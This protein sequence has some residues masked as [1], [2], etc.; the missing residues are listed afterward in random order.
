V[1]VASTDPIDSLMTAKEVA[2]R[3]GLNR[4]TIW[5]W[6]NSGLV[7]KPVVQRPK[8]TRWSAHQVSAAIEALKTA[9]RKEMAS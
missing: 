1:T 8:F 5:R 2:A 9:E 3:Y 7:P 6:V 4:T